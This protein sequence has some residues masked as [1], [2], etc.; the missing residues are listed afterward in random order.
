MRLVPRYRLAAG[1]DPAA[2][3]ARG[4][5]RVRLSDPARRR[6][7]GAR[8]T[9]GH[10]NAISPT[11]TRGPKSTSRAPAGSASI[12]RPAC[13]PAKGTSRS[14]ARQILATPRPSSATPTSANVE[15]DV[16]M[17]VTRVHE[18]PRVTKPYTRRAMGG[19]RRAGRARRRRSRSHTTCVSR[20][21][22]SR[23]SSRSTTWKA[24]SGTV[25]ALSRQKTR[26]GRSA[27]APPARHDSRP[28]GFLHIGQGK[29]YPGEP[30]PR[31]ALGVYWRTDGVAL[32]RDAALIA[33]TRARGK[34]D[35]AA[36]RDLRRSARRRAWASPARCA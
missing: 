24:P 12:R 31:W 36:A 17:T 15:F 4:A 11:C 27:A 34:A 10:P 8:R 7:Q 29:W 9:L 33:D 21:A 32:W 26:A 5:L 22:A 20:R 13:S 18:D 30:L 16:A 6:R 2:P 1:A 28:D 25:A 14:R 19:H 35:V 3:W 23:R